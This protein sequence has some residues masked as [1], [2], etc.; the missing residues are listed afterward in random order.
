[1]PYY[2]YSS[3][4]YADTVFLLAM[5]VTFIFA[6]IAQFR[7]KSTFAKYAKVHSKKGI[8]GFEAARTILNRNGLNHVSI[9]KVQG[10]LSDHYDPRANV[11]RLSAE[12]YDSTSVAS[13]GVAAHECGHAIQYAE[14]YGPIK[15]RAAIIPMTRVGSTLAF[16]LILLGLVLSM[17]GLAYVG[18][19]FFSLSTL[20]Q[21]VTLPVEYNA[22]ARAIATLDEYGTL[23]D[24]ES[25][26]AKK[27]LSAAALTYVAALAT[28]L[29]QLLRMIAIVSNRKR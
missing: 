29:V 17:T 26:Q 2:Y 20:F 1:M 10:T 4:Y 21:L 19:A 8:T 27:V 15:L 23:D 12:V 9:E 13:I 28:S 6:L 5:L 18:V 24:E 14:E 25:K 22:S 16:P 3:Y 7:V 11:I